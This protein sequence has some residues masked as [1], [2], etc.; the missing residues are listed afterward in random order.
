M[1]DYKEWIA[2]LGNAIKESQDQGL[3]NEL[4]GISGFSGA[5]LV[6]LLQRLA[7]LQEK[8]SN[9]C[10]LEV[11]VFQGMT[12]LSVASVLKKEHAYGID[13]FSQF[14]KGGENYSVIQRRK[15]EYNIDNCS[16]INMDFEDALEGIEKHIKTKIGLY[17]IDG[18]HDYRSQLLCLELAK[19]FLAERAIIVI[20]DSNYRHVRLANSDFLKFNPEFKLVFEAYT[21]KHPVNMDQQEKQQAQ[22]GWWNGINVLVRD[23]ENLLKSTLPATERDRTLYVNDH[24]VHQYK[25][26][27]VA[28]EATYAVTCLASLRPLRFIKAAA[29]IAKKIATGTEPKR[30]KYLLAN[31]YSENLA[32][33]NLCIEYR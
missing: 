28:P 23:R 31:T 25:Y 33:F 26:A 14:D 3:L 4:S 20:D 21:K 27:D 11:G 9:S 19:P 30:G 7:S 8:D 22:Q 6:G 1:S 17:F 5:R 12:L 18:P 15:A 10:Y 24:L 32:D 16:L 13:N 2:Q 29:T